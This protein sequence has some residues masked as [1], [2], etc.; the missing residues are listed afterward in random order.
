VAGIRSVVWLAVRQRVAISSCLRGLAVTG[1][2]DVSSN[3][4]G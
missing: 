2:E 4:A 3:I 1:A